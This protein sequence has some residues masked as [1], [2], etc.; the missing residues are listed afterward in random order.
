L[1]IEVDTSL[2]SQSVARLLDQLIRW[3]GPPKRI[4]MNNGP[5]FTG[6]KLDAWAY[7]HHVTF[8]CIDPGKPMQNGYL[9]SLNDKFRDA[10]LLASPIISELEVSGAH[11]VQ[12]AEVPAAYV[13]G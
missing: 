8:D 11:R 10:C 1:A 13:I 6:H 7:Q 9:E 4:V 2:R 5:E 3:C 12:E